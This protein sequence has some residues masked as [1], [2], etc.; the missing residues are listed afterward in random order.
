MLYKCIC[1][2]LTYSAPVDV[3]IFRDGNVEAFVA[4]I[5]QTA[6]RLGRADAEGEEHDEKIL[7][8]DEE[9]DR[10]YVF[11]YY[12]SKTNGSIGVVEEEME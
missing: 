10:M 7:L 1:E 9:H 6:L 4:I 3:F 12:Y 2:N 11:W 8:L 5:G